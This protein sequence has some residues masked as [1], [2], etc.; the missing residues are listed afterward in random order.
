MKHYARMFNPI[1]PYAWGSRHAIAE[2]LG[3]APPA[4]EPQAELWMGAHPRA[5]STVA[6]RGR[7]ESLSALIRR[8]PRDIL[9]QWVADR[10]G[11]RLPFL[12]KVLAAERPL[13]VQVHP[14]GAQ[15]KAGFERE[16]TQ[17]IPLEADARNY[18]DASH[19]PECLCAL[20]H[21]W[22]LC[23]FRPIAEIVEWLQV[24]CPTALSDALNNLG[25]LADP[26]ALSLFFGHLMRL[27]GPRRRHLIDEA[28]T[29]AERLMKE[30][31]DEGRWILE[32]MRTFPHDVGVLAPAL[33]NLIRLEPGQALFLPAGRLHAYLK[34]T[35]IELM[36]NSDNVLRCGLTS[37]HVDAKELLRTARFDSGRPE[38]ILP[39]RRDAGEQRYPTPAD[40]F[41]LSVLS[42]AAGRAYTSAQ[43]RSVEILLCTQ[44]DA[45]IFPFGRRGSV[46]RIRKGT[47]FLVPAAAPAYEIEGEATIYRACVPLRLDL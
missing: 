8:H 14:N 25:R 30:R 32:L 34:G 4:D 23:G 31:P 40:E 24:I 5:S 20:S 37:K 26:R 16:T 46:Q 10:Y 19:K 11:P 39:L 43:D 15:A 6:Y 47:S 17:G 2:L 27:D 18:K 9:G 12:F 42:V 38:I 33:L 35:A 1:M 44:G 28:R 3:E 13:S 22:A 45:A 7:R 21:F 36:A 29:G 41:Q